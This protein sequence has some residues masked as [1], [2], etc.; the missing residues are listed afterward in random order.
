M[1]YIL[2]IEDDPH[3][4]RLVEKLLTRAGHRVIIAETG[5]AGL[6]HAFE[7][8]PDAFLIDLGLPDIDGQTVIA[9]LRQ[10]P[11]FMTMP[12]IA[13]TAYPE[14]NARQLAR[15]YGCT[16][17]IVKPIDSRYFATQ[18]ESFVH[19]PISPQTDAEKEL[20]PS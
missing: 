8:P 17:V 4:G 14:A 15:A 12:L 2:V 20:P 10:E 19:P 11:N 1:A 13:F 9:L 6:M 7:T 18:V 3:T 16:G 5:E